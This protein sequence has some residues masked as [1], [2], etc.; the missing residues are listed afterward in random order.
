MEMRFDKADC[1]CL[2]PVLWQVQNQ[3]QTQE[4]RLSEGMPDVGSI[5]GCWG[6]PVLRGKEWA[7]DTVIVSAGMMVWVLYVPEDGSQE[8]CMETWIPFQLRYDMGE[9]VPEGKL[10]VRCLTRFADA[11]SVSARKILVRAG[12][13]CLAEG[14]SAKETRISV[15]SQD[16]ADV[17]LKKQ[18][19]P[20]RLPKEAGEKTF[21][22]DEELSLPENE[23]RPEKMVACTMEPV[24]T[25]KRVLGSKVVFRGEGKAHCLYQGADGRLHSR[26]LSIPFSQ[27]GEL[28][29]EYGADAQADVA[30]T[31]TGMEPELTED[32]LLRLKGGLTGQYLISDIENTEVVEDAYCPGRELKLQK[33]ELTLPVM[34]ESRTERLSAEQ[35]IPAQ[36]TEVV[37]VCFRPDFPRQRQ[38]DGWTDLELPG[39]FSML[40]YGP[41]GGLHSASARWE[42]SHR[43]KT[44]EGSILTASPQCGETQAIPEGDTGRVKCEI[45]MMTALFSRRGIPMV[46]GLELGEPLAQDPNRPSLILRRREGQSLWEIAKECGSTVGAILRA[47][48]LTEEPKD[49]RM[50]LIP[51]K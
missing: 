49:N 3:E 21:T 25:E 38:Q 11:R 47:N 13:A 1:F 27:Y 26:D 10:R 17:E 19:Y 18:V 51:V 12:L 40:Y 5:L 4:L 29:R 15:P 39:A 44:D 45:N 37:E 34:L 31:V 22:L 33:E 42:G 20:F 14:Y 9:D 50:L 32:G 48:K 16:T 46:S 41:E 6:Q 24:L 28:D 7:G 36:W 8:Q 43:I 30:L 35:N 2:E 23:S